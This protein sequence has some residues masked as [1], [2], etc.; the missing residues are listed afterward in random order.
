MTHAGLLLGADFSVAAGAAGGG[1]VAAGTSP[2]EC[3]SSVRLQAEVT[4]THS[5]TS[6]PKGVLTRIAQA[7]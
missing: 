2:D 5:P 1:V 3:G 7:V 6:S 4:E